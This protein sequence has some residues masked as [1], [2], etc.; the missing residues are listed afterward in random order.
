VKPAACEY[1]RPESLQ[2]ALDLLARHGDDAKPLAGGQSLLPL[3]A[4]RLARPAL[5]VD[6]QALP[7][8]RALELREGWWH[9]GAMV[10]QREVEAH[11]GLPALVRA[12][13]R[14][15]GHFQIR[16]RGTA[17]GSLAHLD[18]A[19]EWPALALATGARLLLAGRGGRRELTA[20]EFIRGPLESALEPDELLLEVRVP[21]P[22]AAWG[23]AE[24][25]RRPGDFALAGALRHAERVVAFGAGPVPQRL[26]A[27]E[28]ALAEGP[29]EAARIRR[30]AAA[31]LEARGDVHASS[32]YRRTVTAELVARVVTRPEEVGA[33]ATR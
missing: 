5:L 9:I 4:L 7:E 23:F 19:A 21:G 33:S 2:E 8:L 20:E 24:V 17:G 25:A 3:M 28:S 32:D 10:T 30:L 31:D 12:A 11:A 15:I 1:A 22:P 26:R 16:N 18:P 6:L 27:V 29:P 13:V 14:Q